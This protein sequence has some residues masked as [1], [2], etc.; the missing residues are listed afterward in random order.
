MVLA[1]GLTWWMDVILLH[2]VAAGTD[3]AVRLAA[4]L[5]YVGVDGTYTLARALGI[6]AMVFAY[7]TVVL[8]LLPAR[9]NGDQAGKRAGTRPLRPAGTLHRQ[10]GAA[11][12]AL[13][14]AH[15]AVPY[16]S[17]VPPYGGWRTNFVPWA[18]PV[19]WGLKAA[20]WESLGVLA[21]YL[22]ALT[23][24]TYYL[25]RRRRRAWTIVHRVAVLAYALA[26]AHV[27]LL[28]TD[29]LV[30]GPARL[31]LLAAQVPLLLLVC[32]RLTSEVGPADGR[33][34]RLAPPVRWTGAVISGAAA[35]GL[36]ALTVL[37]ATGEYAQGMRL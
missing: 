9:A 8:G 36:A 32:R 12:L 25:V 3:H 5:T 18:Q 7:A 14:A 24:P 16:S 20:S 11:T 15:A 22:L 37:S 30:A 13:V 23:G 10:A 26:V 31:A 6:T 21:F 34:R 27:F 35:A 2:R 1:A 28:G 33:A 29:F 4:V 19:S 17:V